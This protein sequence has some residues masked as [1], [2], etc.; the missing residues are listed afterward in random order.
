M[1]HR[2]DKMEDYTSRKEERTSSS[3]NKEEEEAKEE[4]ESKID[5]RG[6][7]ESEKQLLI[8]ESALLK[9]Y[10]IEVF[11]AVVD[12]LNTMKIKWWISDGTLLGWYRNNQSMLPH[13]YDMD[14]GVT[15]DDIQAVWKN[16]AKL[17]T[18]IELQ[19]VSSK[20][21][22]AYHL[23]LPPEPESGTFF[24]LA[25]TDIISYQKEATR[26]IWHCNF[27]VNGMH[28]SY[29]EFPNDVLF[30]LV[31]SKFEGV[32][33]YVPQKPKEYLEILYGYIGE[34]AVW[35]PATNKYKKKNDDA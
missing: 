20:K 15:E 23:E 3:I 25:P 27:D 16:R 31:E 6:T 28:L 8:Q 21:L 7:K 12:L 34:D 17:P 1:T 29:S 32:S 2:A 14:I 35:D 9:P 18:N 19:N 11:A 26:D 10:R 24:W 5:T 33:V 30:P 22:A 4:Y 13:D